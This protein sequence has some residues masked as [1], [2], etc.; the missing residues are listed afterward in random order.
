MLR[1][2]SRV[3]LCSRCVTYPAPMVAEFFCT[4]CRTPLLNRAPLD[5]A[6]QCSLCRLGLSGVDAV[7]AYGSHEGARRKLVDLLN[8]EKI[9]PLARPL[10]GFVVRALPQATRPTS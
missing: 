4:G 9:R 6:G 3:P 8:Y 10:A 2:V 7:F 1:A 5:D